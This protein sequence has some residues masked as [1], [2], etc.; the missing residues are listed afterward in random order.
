MKNAAGARRGRPPKGASV[1][2][3]E[4]IV[5]ATFQVI[6]TAGVGGVS[7]RAVGR[8]LGVDP[9][10]LYNHVD[11]KEGLLDA[12]A[13]ALLS[14]LDLPEPTGD[15]TTDLRAIA[16]A[17]RAR[18]LS[19]PEA[20][21]LVLTRQLSSF[22]GLAPIEAVL[23]ILRD[24][25]FDVE[26]SVHLLRVV[27]AAL[28]GTLLR[29][30]NAGPTYGSEDAAGIAERTAVLEASELPAVTAAASHLARFDADKEFEYA[31]ELALDAVVHRAPKGQNQR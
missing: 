28:I 9:K 12:V 31:V 1:L 19:H 25:G 10:S 3:R 8:V 29:E 11:G 13:E 30:V 16:Y 27:L 18:A 15:L 24:A 5:G 4:T 23:R 6:D 21:S 2:S 17:F 14:T 26:E 22:E 7:M 20:A